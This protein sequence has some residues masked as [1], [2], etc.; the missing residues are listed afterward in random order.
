MTDSPQ[1]TGDC[2]TAQT[3]HGV[4][5]DDVGGLAVAI[6]NIF[7]N[8]T[9]PIV[10]YW[11][12]D[13]VHTTVFM[14]L[15]QVYPILIATASSVKTDNL[16]LF[17]AHFATAVTAS[18]ISVYIAYSSIRDFFLEPNTLFRR[19]KRGRKVIRFLGASLPFFWIAINVIT[20]FHPR[21]FQNSP[22]YCR[23][24]QFSQWLLFQIVSNFVGV[25]DVMGRRDLWSDIEGR[26]GLGAVSLI[27]MWIWA[28]YLVRH[29]FDILE[30]MA[31]R[32]QTQSR[33][34]RR[35]CIRVIL[36]IKDV[37]FACWHVISN[38]HS[39]MKVD[40][41][42]CLHWSWVLGIAK[43]MYLPD[44]QLSYGQ[45]MS[46][47]IIIPPF[48][49]T[50]DL[51]VKKR[52]KIKTAF[53]NSPGYLMDGF[54]FLLFGINNPWTDHELRQKP[55]PTAIVPSN[56]L[57]KT[58]FE[59][60]LY[61]LSFCVTL[62][63]VVWIWG[64][65]R[66]GSVPNPRTMVN[67]PHEA[68]KPFSVAL[69]IYGYCVCCVNL[70]AWT[71]WLD[72]HAEGKNKQGHSNSYLRHTSL[73]WPRISRVLSV[74]LTIC[75]LFGEFIM[76]AGPIFAPPAALP[77]AQQWQWTHFCASHNFSSYAILDGAGP[78]NKTSTVT[79]FLKDHRERPTYGLTIHEDHVM[80]HPYS[81]AYA[82]TGPLG[83]LPAYNVTYWYSKDLFS[84]TC[85]LEGLPPS[86]PSN[87][88]N[89]CATGYHSSFS[90]KSRLFITLNDETTGLVTTMN[91]VDAQWRF[92][93]DAPSLVLAQSSNQTLGGKQLAP[94]LLQTSVTKRN[95]CEVLKVC[96]SSATL[97]LQSI[98]AMGLIL[99][100]QQ[101]YS[102]SCLQP[103]IYS[104]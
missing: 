85:T 94:V 24:V 37:P 59:K 10:L 54:I 26:G 64:Y 29:R 38:A 41:V 35:R 30:E 48:L 81:I 3:I 97:D 9:L 88:L 49:A 89:T 93:D 11:S 25:L 77:L 61:P 55:V 46:L 84:A 99:R 4:I 16:S 27:S 21:A 17:D 33:L 15:S 6:S 19:I 32:R 45:I 52:S 36:A 82:S 5:N 47:F 12:E 34:E 8:V 102:L 22:E 60:L 75:I 90:T 73:K 62:L 100:A 31:Y 57:W 78:N 70:L 80:L 66:G 40:I 86:D 44:Y 56:S 79:F 53:L 95:H 98:V 101:E 65:V 20:S 13:N 72:Q 14:L 96:M 43:G 23:G 1:H 28:I 76:S 91:S 71:H 7:I 39:W 18:P 67:N 42:M 104:I 83:V 103:R 51:V 58:A 50:Y 2:F 92:T 63:D 74:A 87:A 68:W 69:Y